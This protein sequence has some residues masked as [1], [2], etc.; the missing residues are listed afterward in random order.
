VSVI[1]ALANDEL[2]DRISCKNKEAV[3]QAL[4]FLEKHAAFTRTG[5]GGKVILKTIGFVVVM[6]EHCTSRAND[7]QLLDEYCA[8][9]IA[10]GQGMY[11][12][13]METLASCMSS[14]RHKG[15]ALEYFEE[16]KHP[17][18]GN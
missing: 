5:E 1:W 3:L 10:D 2:R 9:T 4:Q 18:N 12:D 16:Q 7:M 11:C 14:S 6:F 8:A 17:S 15:M 13:R